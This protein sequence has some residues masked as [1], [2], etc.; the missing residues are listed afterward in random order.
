VQKTYPRFTNRILTSSAGPC[1]EYSEVGF[2]P[3]LDTNGNL[4]AIN[5]ELL[6]V[7]LTATSRFRWQMEPSAGLHIS[8]EASIFQSGRPILAVVPDVSGCGHIKAWAQGRNLPS[9]N[10]RS[11]SALSVTQ[12]PTRK[13][14]QTVSLVSQLLSLDRRVGLHSPMEM[15]SGHNS[16]SILSGNHNSP[17]L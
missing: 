5:Y 14:F 4:A 9:T 8:N 2:S 15:N 16:N 13:P 7:R 17:P 6:T 12:R 1:Y 10:V 3:G 11:R